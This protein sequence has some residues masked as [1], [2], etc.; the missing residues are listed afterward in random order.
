MIACGIQ[1]QHIEQL[2]HST[3]RAGVNKAEGLVRN[4]YR[5]PTTAAGQRN[6]TKTCTVECRRTDLPTHEL[7]PPPAYFKT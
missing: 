1:L 5:G 4:E 6:L 3:T 7:R 2:V